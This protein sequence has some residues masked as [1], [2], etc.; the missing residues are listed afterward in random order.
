MIYSQNDRAV[1]REYVLQL[2]DSYAQCKQC[3]ERSKIMGDNQDNSNKKKIMARIE[4]VIYNLLD[5]A[6]FFIIF[7]EVIKNKRSTWYVGYLSTP[8]YYRHRDKAYVNF[9][10]CLDE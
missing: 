9:L 8:T 10:S 2:A 5:E 3:I 7:N 6:D 1:N 4:S